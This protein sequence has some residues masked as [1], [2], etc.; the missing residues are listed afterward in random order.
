[1]AWNRQAETIRWEQG[2]VALLAF[3][4]DTTL[5]ARACEAVREEYRKLQGYFANNQH[6]TD[7]PSDRAHGWD[8]GSGPAEAGC[9]L[10]GERVKGS[11]MRWLE[12]GAEA[13]GVLRALYV[14]GPKVWDGFWDQTK[15]KA[16]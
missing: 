4:R 2:G 10:I 9:Q 1:V 7:D 6:R 14:S 15:R 3:R 11:G 16:G 5:P 12:G 8:I 13:V